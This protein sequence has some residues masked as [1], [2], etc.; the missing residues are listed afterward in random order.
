MKTILLIDAFAIIHRAFF[1]IPELTTSEGVPTNAIYGFF[2]MVD[3]AISDFQP[4]YVAICFDTPKKTF[5]KELFKEYQSHRPETAA[6]FKIQIPI[7]R[8][9]IDI[10][11]LKRIEKPGFE[12]D[13]V[14]GTLSKK[15]SDE[16]IKILILT[17]DKDI[18][19]LSRSNVFVI[20]PLKGISSIN[21]YGPQQVMERFGIPPELIPD[22]KALMGDSSDNYKGA[23]GIGPKTATKLLQEYKSIEQ[24]IENIETVMPQRIRTILKE[25]KETIILSKQ[26]ATILTDMKLDCEL[27]DFKFEGFAPQMKEELQKLQLFTLIGRL[28]RN[29][30]KTSEQKLKAEQVQQIKKDIAK[31]RADNAQLDL[32]S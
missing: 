3:K 7:I 14:I 8:D 20:T 15:F 23:P 32:F 28:Y 1:A 5:R 26:L 25:N 12:A 30:A 2:L 4:E 17:G 9:L 19:Q 18:M 13:D 22:F 11:G 29:K 16:D 27:Q 10:S 21:I 6:G 24:L 31:K